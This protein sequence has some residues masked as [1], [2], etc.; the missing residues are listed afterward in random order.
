MTTYDE[1]QMAALFAAQAPVLLPGDWDDV[2]GRA[3][4]TRGSLL[5]VRRRR[6]LRGHRRSI[7]VLAVAVVVVALATA[8]A[9]AVRA[10]YHR[11]IVGLAPVGATPSTPTSGELVLKFMFGHTPG[12]PGRFTIDMY[13]DGRL[14]WS[15]FGDHSRTDEYADSTGYLEQRLTPEGVQLVLADVLASGLVDNDLNLTDGRGL[16]FGYIDYR[17]EERR[18]RVTWGEDLISLLDVNREVSRKPPT[19]EQ[20]SALIHLDERL[21]DPASWLPASAWEDPEIRAYVPSGYLVCIQGKQ[22]IGLA[23][24]LALLPPRAADLLRP[25]E[26]TPD[27]YTNLIGTFRLWCS[28]LTNDEARALEQALNDAGVPVSEDQDGTYLGER[29]GSSDPAE[30]SAEEFSLSFHPNLPG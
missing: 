13:A 24:V 19:A 3:G 27:E 15:R 18:V 5:R 29:F 4:V 28:D 25:Q 6:A 2:L 8:S 30:F 10:V 11:G 16:Y 21:E 26:N 9:L 20:A 17:G 14:I 7:V 1:K 23:R 12:D 22:K